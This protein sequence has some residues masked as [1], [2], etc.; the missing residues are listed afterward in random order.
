[1]INYIDKDCEFEN[2]LTYFQIHDAF[3]T[4]ILIT[5]KTYGINFQYT[6]YWFQKNGEEYTSLIF[7]I[8]GQFVLYLTDNS[9]LEEIESF[10]EL[11]GFNSILYDNKYSIKIGCRK[12]FSGAIMKLVN[13]EILLKHRYININDEDDYQFEICK[14]DNFKRIFNFFNSVNSDDVKISSYGSFATDL[15]SKMRSGCADVF[16]IYKYKKLHSEIVSCCVVLNDGFNSIIGPVATLKEYRKKDFA[17]A[18]ISNVNAENK[19]KNI[20]LFCKNDVRKE[21]YEK[22]GFMPVGQWK[23]VYR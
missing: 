15:F 16:S 1:M 12:I 18:L 9:N 5:Y 13:P 11:I 23:E 19:Q 8:D 7:R 4:K 6:D 20:I 14:E 22:M 3:L 21:I 2:A 10:I 17:K